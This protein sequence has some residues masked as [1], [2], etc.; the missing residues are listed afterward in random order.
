MGFILI[1]LAS[2]DDMGSADFKNDLEGDFFI[3][4]LTPSSFRLHL[5]LGL[6]E[7]FC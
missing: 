5:P 1:Q 4:L 2:S 6:L 7:G 3:P